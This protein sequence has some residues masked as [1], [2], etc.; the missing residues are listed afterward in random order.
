MLAH[1]LHQHQPLLGLLLQLHQLF[2]VSKGISFI[3]H[4]LRGFLSPEPQSFGTRASPAPSGEKPKK[5]SKVSNSQKKTDARARKRDACKFREWNVLEGAVDQQKKV[6][7]RVY[8]PNGVAMANPKAPNSRF[9]L[10]PGHHVKIWLTEAATPVYEICAIYRPNNGHQYNLVLIDIADAT[11]EPFH[12]PLQDLTAVLEQAAQ[13]SARGIEIQEAE[14]TAVLVLQNVEVTATPLKA[15]PPRHKS[16]VVKSLADK[17]A[18]SSQR[19]EEKIQDVKADISTL[20][21]EVTQ[22]RAEVRQLVS[23][24]AQI[25]TDLLDANKQHI[26][27]L[28]TLAH[29]DR[30]KT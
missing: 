22:L 4:L 25:R 5:K 21:R 28:F 20:H 7:K 27:H 10:R 1:L 24:V 9:D 30:N 8:F 12:F 18:I 14:T 3:A 2:K 19:V 15:P 11:S 23:G 17:A 26:D 13:L 16:N 29:S 6:N